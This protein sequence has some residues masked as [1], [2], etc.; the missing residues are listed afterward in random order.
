MDVHDNSR[1]PGS[2]RVKR[3]G[4]IKSRR[5]S[6]TILISFY[7]SY[8]FK[9][10]NLSN[11]SCHP[12]GEKVNFSCAI[13]VNIQIFTTRISFRAHNRELDFFYSRMN[14]SKTILNL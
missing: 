10:S 12:V 4:I 1:V 3:L 9:I 2:E 13:P 7:D 5:K 6:L 14:S 11:K 8:S